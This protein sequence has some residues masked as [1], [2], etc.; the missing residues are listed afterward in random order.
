M[1]SE[2]IR[3]IVDRNEANN[4]GLISTMEEIQSKFGYLPRE[5]L[6]KVAEKTNRSL[7]DIYGVATFYRAFSLEPRGEHLVSACLGT[8]CHV[9]GASLVANE[10]GKQLGI[11]PG[12]TTQDDKFTFETVNCLGAC[13]LGPVVVVDGHYFSQ[14]NTSTVSDILKKSVEGFDKVEVATDER[15]FP[16]E[17]SCP[18]CNHSLMA[19]DHQMDGYPS[20]WITHS[21]GLKHGWLRMSSLYGSYKSE[22]EYDIPENQVINFFCPHCHTELIGAADCTECGTQMIPMI[23]RGGGTVQVCPR[24]GCKGHILDL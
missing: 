22:A 5:A 4:N 11:E 3:E 2:L 19:P 15:I 12:E 8:A 10:I 17:V 18:R 7:V 9:R 21:Y 16:I 20:I 13:A 1:N 23:V 24:K 14:V 6:E